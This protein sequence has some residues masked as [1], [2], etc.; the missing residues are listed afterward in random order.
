V[1][2]SVDQVNEYFSDNLR[3]RAIRS[4]ADAGNCQHGTRT[5]WCPV[6]VTEREAEIRREDDLLRRE[7][8]VEYEQEAL[9]AEHARLD[10]RRDDL[11][12][13]SAEL[14]KAQEELDAQ[15]Q[16]KRFR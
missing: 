13:W 11:E 14:A 15:R 5:V 4:L 3:I 16:K 6:H 8:A 10:L 9:A 7:R 1:P 12:R 2:Y